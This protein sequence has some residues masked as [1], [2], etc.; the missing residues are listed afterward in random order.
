MTLTRY[1]GMTHGFFRLYPLL[2][3]GKAAVAEAA[4]ALEA[5]LRARR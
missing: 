2:D 3:G 4:T 5:A 1:A